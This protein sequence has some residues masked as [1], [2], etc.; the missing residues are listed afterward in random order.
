MKGSSDAW[1]VIDA[2]FAVKLILPDPAREEI[3]AI[4]DSLAESGVRLAAPALWSYETTS[5]IAK[6]VQFGYLLPDDG[7][8]A[9]E[10]LSG[11]DV[12]L[13]PPDAVQNYRASVWSLK[14]KRASAYDCYYL[15]LAE[16][17]GCPL[18]TAD[19]E[20]ANAVGLPWVRLA[21]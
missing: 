20:L 2:S 5:A 9:V 19:K 18:W 21:G 16:Q 1:A 10:L 15:A 11:M 4:A 12:T 13:F 17:L 3:H 7:I 6:A 8:R 14:L